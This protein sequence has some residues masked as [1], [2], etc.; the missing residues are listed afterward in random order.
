MLGF[1]MGK[2]MT[3]R[4]VIAAF[5]I[6]IL[7]GCASPA[8]DR[9]SAGDDA[10]KSSSNKIGVINFHDRANIFLPVDP[11]SRTPP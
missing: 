9:E 7:A 2:T 6:I 8:V 10:V 1:K 3:Y 5:A 11:G 4:C